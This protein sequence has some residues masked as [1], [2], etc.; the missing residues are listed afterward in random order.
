MISNF[1]WSSWLQEREMKRQQAA[2]LKEQVWF[3]QKHNYFK[4]YHTI[5]TIKFKIVMLVVKI[6]EI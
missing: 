3:F 5:L 6:C 4:V 2:L 1:L